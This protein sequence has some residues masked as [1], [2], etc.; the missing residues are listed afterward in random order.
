MWIFYTFLHIIRRRNKVGGKSTKIYWE[1][2]TQPELGS[3]LYTVEP[4]VRH[5]C[6]EKWAIFSHRRWSDLFS[7]L[8]DHKDC[9]FST[10]L[11]CMGAKSRESQHYAVLKCLEFIFGYF[12]YFYCLSALNILPQ[13]QIICHLGQPVLVFKRNHFLILK[14]HITE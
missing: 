13:P 8:S 10:I 3:I 7:S 5:T 12:S 11:L 1:T 9:S 2:I 6:P 4:F 14:K